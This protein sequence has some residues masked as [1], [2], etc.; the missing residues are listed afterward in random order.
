MV[1]YPPLP[2]APCKK[3]WL[4]KMNLGGE[5]ERLIRHLALSDLNYAAA[6]KLL[7]DRYNN[8]RLLV[9]AFLNKILSQPSQSSDTTSAA[10]LKSLHDTTQECLYGLKNLGVAVDTWDPLI[11]RKLDKTTLT[12][13]EQSLANPKQ[14]Q[15]L[16][17]FLQF[18]E[19]RFQ[20]L[21]A[22]GAKNIKAEDS[23]KKL[24]RTTMSV[25]T[26][27][28]GCTMCKEAHQLFACN[29]FLR[30]SPTDRFHHLRKHK[31]CINC[32]KGGHFASSCS[33]R[34]C[35]KCSKKHNTLVHFKP[36]EETSS[37]D[38]THNLEK[39][40]SSRKPSKAASEKATLTAVSNESDGLDCYVFLSTALVNDGTTVSCRVILDSGSQVNIVSER[41][42]RK[43]N[44]PLAANAKPMRL[45]GVGHSKLETHRRVSVE[46]Q[47]G[48]TRYS[49]RV[50][51][52]VLPQI[53]AP[54][55]S[56]M[57]DVSSWN[58]PKNI[59]LSHP[60]FNES[61]RVDM[62]IGTEYYHELLC[63]GQIKLGKNLPLLQNTLLGWI[64][65]GK[66]KEG[67]ASVA[68]CGICTMDE[69]LERS[70]ERFWQQCE[71][72][73]NQNTMLSNNQF[74]VS[75]P[76]SDSAEK[77]GS[78]ADIAK[79]RF[80]ALE[81][82]LTKNGD[83]RKQYTKFMKEYLHLGHMK[84]VNPDQIPHP[85]YFLPHHCVLKPDSTSTKL[86]VVFDASAKTSTNVSLNDIL[87][88]GPTVRVATGVL[89]TKPICIIG[90][91][92]N[93]KEEHQNDTTREVLSVTRFT[94]LNVFI[95]RK[96]HVLI[97]N[98][99]MTCTS[100]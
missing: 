51:A 77:L 98:W 75:L 45:Q 99:H 59:K 18:L 86:R 2:N 15:S 39:I 80:Y 72:M 35:T 68:T 81:R 6:W 90:T 71:E 61:R 20:S 8:P 13:Y 48:V 56:R 32:L 79:S 14:L 10:T 50:E 96:P 36:R 57:F 1:D 88:V 16:A 25:T 34:G 60:R 9:A 26:V 95:S 3:N 7:Q 37:D 94:M 89:K 12:M 91:S 52:I 4:L 62:L 74:T 28:V 67:D 11:L 43:L 58:V 49:T 97:R 54:Q 30:L 5:A 64:V 84:E 83:L 92:G 38:Q 69:P 46:V 17:E 47:S 87:H 29:D 100:I 33:S 23:K 82:K 76:F 21:E 19:T 73:F 65:T 42:L 24:P 40:A 63:V 22:L 31:L 41:L 85:H 44:M 93:R 66:L 78:S 55:P 70:I 53:V 27:S